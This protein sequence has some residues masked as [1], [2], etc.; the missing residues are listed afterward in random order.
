MLK[1]I[2]LFEKFNYE[3]TLRKMDTHCTTVRTFIQ[4]SRNE[5]LP[6]GS[7]ATL[8]MI[9]HFNDNSY[10]REQANTIKGF[11]TS[12]ELL[13]AQGFA[14]DLTQALTTNHTQGCQAA[15]Y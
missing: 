1:I 13:L 15:E 11:L 9:L 4:T 10:F 7:L 12:Q 3:K 8:D 14:V 6:E 2:Q 5:L